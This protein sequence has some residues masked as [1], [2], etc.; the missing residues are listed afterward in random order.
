MKNRWTPV[1]RGDIYC[2]PACGG[3]CTL[4]EYQ[5]AVKKADALCVK[6]L[7]IHPNLPWKARVFENLGWHYTA[8]CRGLSVVEYERG[9]TKSYTVFVGDDRE[10]GS[11]HWTGSGSS[12]KAAL[13]DAWRGKRKPLISVVV[14]DAIVG[15]L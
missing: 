4:A 15:R 3:S 14:L 13:R 5:D 8:H 10:S 11:G 12:L 1:Q 2:S 7:K 9:R 6:L